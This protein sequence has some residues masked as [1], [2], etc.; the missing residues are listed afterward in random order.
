MKEGQVPC[1]RACLLNMTSAKRLVGGE[2]AFKSISERQG[3]GD[4]IW[5]TQT[6]HVH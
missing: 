3:M 1:N 2:G 6:G 4:T 5:D